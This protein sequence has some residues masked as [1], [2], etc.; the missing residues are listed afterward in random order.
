M[1]TY[2]AGM[3]WLIVRLKGQSFALPAQE[4]RELVMEPQIAGV[5]DLPGYVRGVMNLRGRMVPVIDLRKRLG[6]TSAPE[7]TADFCAL[8]DQR[9]QDHVDWLNELEATARERREFKLA[10]DPH[11]CAFGRWYDSYQSGNVWIKAVLGRFAE[12]HR[13]IHATAGEVLALQSQG[14][15]EGAGELI[16]VARSSVLGKMIALFA[17]LQELTRESQQE[18]VVVL[19]T[20]TRTVAV[21]VDEAVAVEKFEP[22]NL[23]TLPMTNHDGV[24]AQFGIR[25]KTEPLVLMVA[26]ERLFETDLG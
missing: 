20:D 23:G 11:K 24:V 2:S 19:Q 13:R 1:K 8:M 26:T 21:S 9:S 5:P 25:G 18:I 15:W 3:P 10:T 4:V 6:M 16:E 12:P 14:N 7:E 22:G 17:K